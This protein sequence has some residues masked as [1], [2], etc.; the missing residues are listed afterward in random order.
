M[1]NSILP[2]S[3]M[4]FGHSQSCDNSI[5]QKNT[6]WKA[7]EIDSESE[8]VLRGGWLYLEKSMEFHGNL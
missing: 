4:F 5:R 1:F 8:I 2:D 6:L 3:V 7:H